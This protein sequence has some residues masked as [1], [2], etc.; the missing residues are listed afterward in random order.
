[1]V[2]ASFNHTHSSEGEHLRLAGTISADL[3]E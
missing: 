3:L 1:M 2:V